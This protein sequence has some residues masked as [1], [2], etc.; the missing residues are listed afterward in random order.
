MIPTS[1]TAE[2]LFFF[3][4]KIMKVFN[5]YDSNKYNCRASLLFLILKSVFFAKFLC[6]GKKT[7]FTLF[8]SGTLEVDELRQFMHDIYHEAAPQLH[9]VGLSKPTENSIIRSMREMDIYSTGSIEF[10]DFAV[11][12]I[13]N[14]GFKTLTLF[15]KSEN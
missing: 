4:L 5:H 12:H 14:F 3:N 13:K 9:E 2:L 1:T 8:R 6:P 10:M 15:G 7:N 11:W